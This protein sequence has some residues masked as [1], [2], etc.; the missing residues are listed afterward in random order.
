MDKC[1]KCGECCHLSFYNNDVVIKTTIACPHLLNNLCSVYNNRPT[2]CLTA[3][4]MQSLNLLPTN[5]G[6]LGG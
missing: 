4:K 1:K 2:W 3:E 6:Y 5:C